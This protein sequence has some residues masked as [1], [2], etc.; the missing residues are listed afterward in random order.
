M[1][2]IAID[3]ETA[4]NHPT[5][6]CSIGLAFV[7]DG[8]LASHTSYLIRP[9]PFYFDPF[10]TAIHGLTERD[11]CQ[12]PTFAQLWPEI[13][14]H[15]E[16]AVVAAHNAPFDIGVLRSTLA[17]LRP[18]ASRYAPAL[19]RPALPPSLSRPAIAS[20]ECRLRCPGHLA[21]APPSRI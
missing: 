13:S 9:E 4:N 18:S 12:A 14:A 2:F 3:F 5:S 21:D 10:T 6:A 15:F 8:V 20:A 19:H 7:R 1:D 16:H 11:V 17:F